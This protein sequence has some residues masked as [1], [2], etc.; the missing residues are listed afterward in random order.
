MINKELYID[1]LVFS[2]VFLENIGLMFF[3]RVQ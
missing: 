3:G 2:A 1:W